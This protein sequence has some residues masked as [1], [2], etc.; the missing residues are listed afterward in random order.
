MD[1]PEQLASALAEHDHFLEV[2]LN[3]LADI[4]EDEGV[5]EGAVRHFEHTAVVSGSWLGNHGD[6]EE[7][8]DRSGAHLLVRLCSSAVGDSR[9]VKCWSD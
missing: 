1:L 9:G 7:S 3:G 2:G 4:A 6:R 5:D 8:E